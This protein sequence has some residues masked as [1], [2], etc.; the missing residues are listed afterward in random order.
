MTAK[1]ESRKVDARTSPLCLRGSIYDYHY[2]ESH[3]V[4]IIMGA[5]AWA[6]EDEIRELS[7]LS[8]GISEGAAVASF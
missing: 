1:K 4:I 7:K 6:V 8:R 5:F 3:K 2:G